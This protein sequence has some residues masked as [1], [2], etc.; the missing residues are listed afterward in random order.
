MSF[1]KLIISRGTASNV[2][3]EPVVRIAWYPDKN[4]RGGQTQIYFSPSLAGKLLGSVPTKE[5]IVYVSTFIGEEEDAGSV[6]CRV[7]KAPAPDAAKATVQKI[8]VVRFTVG[9][10]KPLNTELT[11][12]TQDCVY[13]I[14]ES[15]VVEFVLPATFL[16]PPPPKGAGGRMDTL[17]RKGK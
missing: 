7:Y 11:I 1:R 8:G 9:A 10:L 6:Q 4:K 16:T 17:K 12:P 14:A 15:G 13:K 3:N 5:S 2:P